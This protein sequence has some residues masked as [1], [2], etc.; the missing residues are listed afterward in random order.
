MA[1][2]KNRNPRARPSPKVSTRLLLHHRRR[3]RQATLYRL[4]NSG[5][6]L[7]VHKSENYYT[8]CCTCGESHETVVSSDGEDAGKGSDGYVKKSWEDGFDRAPESLGF[9]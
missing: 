3:R 9:V 4:K 5:T 6:G 7:G 2:T 8:C 1:Q